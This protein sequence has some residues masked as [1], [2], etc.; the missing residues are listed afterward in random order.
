MS[1]D[2]FKRLEKGLDDVDKV[3]LEVE[4]DDDE[5]EDAFEDTNDDFL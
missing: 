3:D 1:D 5:I 2:A 4:M